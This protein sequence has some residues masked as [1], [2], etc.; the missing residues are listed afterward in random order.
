MGE[1]TK[2]CDAL[3]SEVKL[4]GGIVLHDL[5]VGTTDTLGNAV[6]LLVQLGTMMVTVLASTRDRV[7]DAGRMP[8]TDT[9]NLTETLVGLTGELGHTPAGDDTLVTLTLGDGNGID[10]LVLLEDAVDGHSLLEEVL[11]ESDLV[12]HAATVHLHLADVRLLLTEVH[13]ADLGVADKTKDGAVLVEL[14]LL[15][16]DAS[17]LGVLLRVTGER[18]LLLG[19]TPVLVEVALALVAQVLS[20]HGA[21]RLEA[22]RGLVVADH[23]DH[24]HGR[25]LDDGDG[26]DDLLLVGL[27]AS[28]VDITEDVSGAGLVAHESRQV[29]LC[30]GIVER[31]AL[32]FALGLS[33]P[34]L[35][36]GAQGAVAGPFELAMR[37][38]NKLRWLEPPC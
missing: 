37:H 11:S 16:R 6:D 34:L 15:S 28:L 18:L 25:G 32:D 23:A 29:R 31:E 14:L 7:L 36:Q 33:A 13:L 27:G 8:R 19:G 17:A 2:G 20:P 9:G 5:V 1:A 30:G 24:H 3:D 22:T 12:G 10:H 26:L 21:A 4:G 38:A 35:G